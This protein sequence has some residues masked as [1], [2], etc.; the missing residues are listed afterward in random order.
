[1]PEHAEPAGVRPH[2]PEQRPHQ[3]RLAR[4]VGAEQADRVVRQLHADAV[5]RDDVVVALGQPGGGDRRTLGGRSHPGTLE[6]QSRGVWSAWTLRLALALRELAPDLAT[7]IPLTH[8][9]RVPGGR[10]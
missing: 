6:R 3:R 8:A 2:E 7:R 9:R 10:G 4:A 5:E 1:M